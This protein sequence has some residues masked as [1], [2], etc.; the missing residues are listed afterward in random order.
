MTGGA[1]YILK[2]HGSIDPAWVRNCFRLFK[3]RSVNIRKL[4]LLKN[5]QP[6]YFAM[7]EIQFVLSPDQVE[8]PDS[9][10]FLAELREQIASQSWHEQTLTPL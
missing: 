9:Q 6:N 5:G 7:L 2:G 3:E 1:A 8:K 10:A 4:V